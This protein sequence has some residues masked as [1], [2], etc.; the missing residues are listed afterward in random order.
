MGKWAES[1]KW[2]AFHIVMCW[3]HPSYVEVNPNNVEEDHRG[4]QGPEMMKNQWFYCFSGGPR[5]A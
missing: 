1:G 3:D 5:G 4:G 2:D